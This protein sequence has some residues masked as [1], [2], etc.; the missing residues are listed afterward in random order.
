MCLEDYNNTFGDYSQPANISG[1]I[2]LNVV[3]K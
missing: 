2:T 3:E 1:S